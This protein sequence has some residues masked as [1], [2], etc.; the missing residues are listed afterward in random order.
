MTISTN[1]VDNNMLSQIENLSSQESQLQ[2]QVSTGL[3]ISAPSDDP[4][5]YGMVMGEADRA[6]SDHEDVHVR[7]FGG[8]VC[9]LPPGA[10]GG[11]WGCPSTEL[12]L[13]VAEGSA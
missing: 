10:K 3:R 11:D 6:G 12:V 7:A 4:T 8:L 13:S 9:W 5:T 2:T 1:S